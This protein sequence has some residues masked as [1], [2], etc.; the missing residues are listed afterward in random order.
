MVIAFI[1]AILII[2][3]IIASAKLVAE[4]KRES[5]ID[6]NQKQNQDKGFYSDRTVTTIDS[7][8]AISIDSENEQW[9]FYNV[10]LDDSRI[11]DYGELLDFEIIEDNDTI[12]QGRTGSALVGGALLGTTGSI[13]G[14]ARSRKTHGVCTKLDIKIIVDDVYDSCIYFPLISS[15]IE[16]TSNAYQT[17]YNKALEFESILRIILS[18]Q[19]DDEARN[20]A[21][22][23]VSENTKNQL[24]ELKEMLDDGLITQEDYEQKK[25][26]IL[27]L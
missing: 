14:A 24:K 18:H 20:T 27:G 23:S 25:K 26:Q 3:S 4:S 2:A 6:N 11:M 9:C 7:K 13:A 8:Y 22:P 21:S 16:K 10:S 17:I 12:I 15:P 19:R 1:V 5:K